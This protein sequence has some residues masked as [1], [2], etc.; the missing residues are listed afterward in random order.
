[1]QNKPLKIIVSLKFEVLKGCLTFN[2]SSQA[3]TSAL[4]IVQSPSRIKIELSS[5]ADVR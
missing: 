2:F 4:L 5:Q 3:R 1:M